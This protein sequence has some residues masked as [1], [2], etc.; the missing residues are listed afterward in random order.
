[1]CLEPV[2][3][4]AMGLSAAGTA[5]NARQQSQYVD[6]VNKQNRIAQEMSNKARQEEQVRQDE[7]TDERMGTFMDVATAADPGKELDDLDTEADAAMREVIAQREAD[8]TLPTWMRGSGAIAD[9]L[10]D[11]ANKVVS[12]KQ[13]QLAAAS[14]LRAAAGGQSDTA[15]SLKRGFS[16]QDFLGDRMRGS[17][18][19]SQQERS[20]APAQVTK[21]SS[22]LGDALL[23]G[24]QFAAN[25][26]GY[27]EGYDATST[28][29]SGG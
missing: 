17:L 13:G 14:R 4:I 23:M 2:T 3:M 29:A 16:A 27:N 22:M 9:E 8:G 11:R 15:L 28:M 25:R 10:T 6:A 1:M 18:G 12:D 21:S 20:I 24:G 7:L 19:A 26:A 5:I